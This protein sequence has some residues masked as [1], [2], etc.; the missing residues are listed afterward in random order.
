MRNLG[1]E[2]VRCAAPE[3]PRGFMC[4]QPPLGPCRA[5]VESRRTVGFLDDP[6]K[7]RICTRDHMRWQ[8]KDD[9]DGAHADGEH[10]ARFRMYE[11]RAAPEHP[12]TPLRQGIVHVPQCLDDVRVGPKPVPGIGNRIKRMAVNVRRRDARVTGFGRKKSIGPAL[13]GS[14]TA[15]PRC[16]ISSLSRMKHPQSKEPQQVSR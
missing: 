14:S 1:G 5:N 2:V 6:G 16:G 8:A 10:H 3:S 13:R 4:D 9:A 12:S 15:T 11:R 7:L